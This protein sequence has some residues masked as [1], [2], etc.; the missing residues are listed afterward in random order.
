MSLTPH[1]LDRTESA[2]RQCPRD[3]QKVTLLKSNHWSFIKKRYHMTIRE[4]QISKSIC[5]G[6]SNEDIAAALRISAG[7]VKTHIRN[8]YRKTWVHNKI[9][10]LLRFIEDINN[11]APDK[12][13]SH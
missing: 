5:D 2:K 1:P 4:L 13:E 12:P 6:M 3:L 7:T 9:S 8:I 11:H 10:M